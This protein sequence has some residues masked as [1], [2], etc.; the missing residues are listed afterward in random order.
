MN[1]L[2]DESVDK[3]IVECLRE[4]GHLVMY[5]AEMEPGLSDEEVFQVA[6][7]ENAI[8]IT[9]DKDFGELVYRLKRISHG[10]VLIRLSGLS[11]VRKGQI[12]YATVSKH[13]KELVHTFTVV[14]PGIIRIRGIPGR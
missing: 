1:F 6:N 4:N 9:A 2:A 3:A 12:V 11:T 10:V 7:K 8:L 5:I 14:T 13:M